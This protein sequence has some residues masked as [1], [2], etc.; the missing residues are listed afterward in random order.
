MADSWNDLK[1]Q[2]NSR[3]VIAA[4]KSAKKQKKYRKNSWFMGTS[5]TYFQNLS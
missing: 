5:R 1:L 2:W 3:E 4:F